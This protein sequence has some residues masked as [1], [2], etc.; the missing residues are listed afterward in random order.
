[1]YVLVQYSVLFAKDMGWDSSLDVNCT[2]NV[3]PALAR[4]FEMRVDAINLSDD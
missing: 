1:M 2:S 4:A 3:H